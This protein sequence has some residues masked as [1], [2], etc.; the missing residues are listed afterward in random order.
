MR[1]LGITDLHGESEVLDRIL[2]QAGPVDVILLGGD[3]THFGTPNAAEAL[4]QQTQRVCP[5][6]LAVAGNCDSPDIELRLSE[7][8]V[9]LCGRGRVIQA[10][11]FYGVS[12]MPPWHG[13]M[14]ELT[15]EQI[16]AALQA[17]REQLPD[18]CPQVLL[19]H[20]PPRDTHLDRTL[21]GAHVGSTAVRRCIEEV[22]PILVVTGHIHEARGIDAL[23]PTTI[24]NCGA[25]RYG[26]YALITLAERVQV[27]LHRAG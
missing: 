20:P 25:A 3:I 11:G 2:A 26:Q 16:A 4:V 27:E 15:E 10:T 12:A 22:R 23:G 13:T 14:Y 6:V 8:G 19:S 7:L 9:S 21:R 5:Q 1:I 17:G 18:S 24:V